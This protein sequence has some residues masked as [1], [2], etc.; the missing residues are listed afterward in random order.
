M[1][2]KTGPG[3]SN[4]TVMNA[5]IG[6]RRLGTCVTAVALTAG[7]AG[8]IVLTGSAALAAGSLSAPSGTVTSSSPVTISATGGSCG[9]SLSVTGP[10]VTRS[11][12][13]SS[14]GGSM[15][16]TIDP[17]QVAN[18]GY[19]AVLTTKTRGITSCSTDSTKPS[20]SWTFAVAPSA[21]TG[22]DATLSGDRQITVTW[23]MVSGPDPDKYYLYDASAGVVLTAV[24]NTSD[25]CSGGR[26]A[27]VVTYPQS[28]YGQESFQVSALR[29]NGTGDYVESE[30]SSSASA[31]LPPPPTS[32][33]SPS[34]GGGGTGGGQ[35]G[36]QGGGGGGGTGGG[37]TAGGGG[38]AGG[39]SG[40]GSTGTGT[41]GG[42]TGGGAGTTSGSSLGLGSIGGVRRGL[43]F[44]ASSGNV[45][46]PPAPPPAIAAPG[47]NLDP[48]IGASPDGPYKETLPYGARAAA[49][50]TEHRG[51]AAQVFHEV[52]VAFDGARLWRSLAGA[53]LLLLAGA[54]LRVWMRRPVI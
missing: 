34:P 31:T 4:S 41:G 17:T 9:G 54:H 10:G 37:G 21:P 20:K 47:A 45:I 14:N 30:K 22:V 24:P 50:Q 36:G 2:L 3:G 23:N 19:Q 26:C 39:G 52:S 44:S 18:G 32:D 53:F 27:E 46:L 12:T 11:A 42:A 1:A 28:T 29:S 8:F 51:A 33:P 16:I 48:V 25:Y 35:G 40:T 7:A 43:T 15:S 5:R 49:G 13:T 38:A 6:V